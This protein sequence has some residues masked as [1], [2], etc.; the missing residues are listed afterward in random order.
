MS[1]LL[2]LADLSIWYR[3]PDGRRIHAVRNVNLDFAAGD[4]VG[5]VGESGSGKTTLAMAAMGLLPPTAELSGQVRY[6]GRDVLDLSGR[7]ARQV[8]WREVAMVFQAA[9]NC[10]N[11]VQPVIA[12]VA[13]PIVHHGLSGRRAARCRAEELLDHVGFPVSRGGAFPHQLSGGMRQRVAIAMALACDPKVL[14]ADEP[15]NSLDV[16]VQAQIVNL[17]ARLCAE[18]EL[19]LILVTHDLPLVLRL[20]D[21][22]TVMHGGRV[23]ESGAVEDIFDRPRHP[24]SELLLE[25][26]P[27]LSGRPRQHA[28]AAALGADIPSLGCSFAPRCAHAHSRCARATPPLTVVGPGR[29]AACW[30]NEQDDTSA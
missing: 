25:S 1:S 15:T 12:Q 29:R 4:R 10:L 28:Q 23:I 16:M 5:I 20:C 7:G 24:Y 17:L 19:A 26:I 6:D 8:R 2:E 11:P 22:A 27:D 21:R 30:L 9:M 18:R 14:I 3:L 13:E